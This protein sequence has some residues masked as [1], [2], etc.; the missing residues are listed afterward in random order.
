M[1][2]VDTTRPLS[3]P[4]NQITC[5]T[6]DPSQGFIFVSQSVQLLVLVKLVS[7]YVCLAKAGNVL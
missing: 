1:L 4:D 6:R 5:K 2:Q 3:Q 7:E